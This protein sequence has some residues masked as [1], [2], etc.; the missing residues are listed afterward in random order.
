[1]GTIGLGIEAK[2]RHRELR[3]RSGRSA[4]FP[5]GKSTATEMNATIEWSSP[6][7]TSDLAGDEVHV[8]RVFLSEDLTATRCFESTLA[9]DEKARAARFIF[10]RDRHRYISARGILRD[11]L[12]KYMQCAPQ[13]I[14]FEYGPHG[15]PAVASP[16]S[17]SGI[18]FNLSHSHELAVVAI[19]R[20]REVGID[21]ELIR[22]E[23]A[24][25]DIAKRYFSVTEVADLNALPAQRKAEGFFLCWTRKEAY[26]KARGD[27]LHMP[28]D[29]FSV[30]LSP[31][32]PAELSSVDESRWK[33]ESFVSSGAQGSRYVAT[34]VAEGKDWKPRYFDRGDAKSE[35]IR[36]V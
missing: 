26:I 10:E 14:D 23:F 29:S 22:P 33:M 19:A 28:L 16:N 30:S 3:E 31:D 36:E 20:N 13:K 9:E 32:N 6:G 1:M 2:W 35:T 12:G 8:W 5:Q 27:G 11:L 15:K 17:R 18:S 7:T 24:G 25:E 34:V 4:T 21:V